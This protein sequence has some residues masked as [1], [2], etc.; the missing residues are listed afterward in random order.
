MER[1]PCQEVWVYSIWMRS[2]HLFDILHNLSNILTSYFQ[3]LHA[4]RLH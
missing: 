1:G 2:F 3:A 4:W